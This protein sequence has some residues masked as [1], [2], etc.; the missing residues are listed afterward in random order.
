MILFAGKCVRRSLYFCSADRP[1]ME[2]LMEDL[3][4]TEIRKRKRELRDELLRKRRGLDEACRRETDAAVIRR[5]KELFVYRQAQTVFC[6]VSVNSEVDTRN[7]IADMLSAGK[8]VAVPRCGGAKRER[9][10]PDAG[11]TGAAEG[12]MEAY[13]IVSLDDLKPGAYNI[14]EPKAYCRRVPPEEI[15]LC[16]VP[17]LCAGSDGTRLGYGGGYYDR[18]LPRLRP[19]AVCA[20]L[21]REI[22][23]GEEPPAEPHDRPMDLSV[24]ESRVI[25]YRNVSDG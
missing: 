6:Y 15:D 16:I 7:L 17:C 3:D 18:Y 25:I 24:S 19:D 9:T 5:L 4:I 23:Q 2:A 13:E 10:A 11:R 1:R 8:R 12:L 20:A 21:C 14:P 22:T